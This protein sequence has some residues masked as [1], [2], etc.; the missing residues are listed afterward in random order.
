RIASL[1]VTR[2]A[3]PA[4]YV[5]PERFHDVALTIGAPPYALPATLSLPEGEGPLPGVVRVHGSG[6]NDRDETVGANKIFKDLAEGLASAGIAV[7]RYEKR[8]YTY[9]DQLTNTITIDDEVVLDAIA[10]TRT[11]AARAEIDRA[12]VFVIGHSLGAMLAPEI[13]QRTGG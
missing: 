6:P 7:L 9:G 8:T 2:P 4:S 11:L 3:P 5:D 13:A 1:Y 10:A 12:R